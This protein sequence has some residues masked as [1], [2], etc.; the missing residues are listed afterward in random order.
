MKLRYL[1]STTV[2]H[3][4]YHSSSNFVGNDSGCFGSLTDVIVFCW[5]T[6]KNYKVQV[7]CDSNTRY[8]PFGTTSIEIQ[9]FRSGI[10]WTWVEIKRSAT[11]HALL[12]KS[13]LSACGNLYALTFLNLQATS[14]RGLFTFCNLQFPAFS[15]GSFSVLTTPT[16]FQLSRIDALLSSF[17]PHPFS[18][19]ATATDAKLWAISLYIWSV[20]P[21]SWAFPLNITL[22]SLYIRLWFCFCPHFFRPECRIYSILSSRFCCVRRRGLHLVLS[23]PVQLWLVLGI[24]E[25]EWL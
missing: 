19:S 13:C 7:C 23:T 11:I 3:I 18:F 6:G 20:S 25:K 4:Y 16:E 22:T 8:G 12:S 24:G 17:S 14:E 1:P 5:A 21:P 2:Y 15:F 10:P 9:F